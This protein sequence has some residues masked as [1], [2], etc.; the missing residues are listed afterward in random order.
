MWSTS[1]NLKALGISQKNK[2]SNHDTLGMWPTSSNLKALGIPRENKNSNHD[3]L[4]IAPT[5]S[6]CNSTTEIPE[7]V[8]DPT[9]SPLENEKK[10]QIM[11]KYQLEQLKIE[12]SQKKALEQMEL[13]DI[14]NSNK[15]LEEEIAMMKKNLS[16]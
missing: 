6:R 1:S 11:L 13:E 4:E 5:S 16:K 9:I 12:E 10:R 8:Y 3:T 15:A 7:E 14:R 2:N